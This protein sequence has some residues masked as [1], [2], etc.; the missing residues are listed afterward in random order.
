MLDLPDAPILDK[1]ALVGGCIRLPVT[2]DADRLRS[3]VARLPDSAWGSVGGRVGVHGAAD[4]LFLRGRA[5]AEGQG[6]I[7]DRPV[8]ES[9]PYARYII[10][11][12]IAAPPLRCLLARLPPGAAIPPHI[13]RELYFWKSLRMHIA[14]ETHDRVWMY[15]DGLSYLM[16]PGEVWVLNNTAAHAV[17][18]EHATLARTHLICDF[19][20]SPRLLELL[21]AA[22]RTL[23]RDIPEVIAHL[24]A[25]GPQTRAAPAG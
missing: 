9:L 16:R 5:P 13:D 19:L 14:V 11:E 25:L 18:N 6:P 10:E 8:L 3:E 1:K 20:P 7:E 4:A 17:W 12:V 21:A 2:V 23:G 22:D 15:C 24:T